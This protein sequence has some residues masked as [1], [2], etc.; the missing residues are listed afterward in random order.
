MTRPDLIATL[1]TLGW[2]V[3]GLARLL[4]RSEETVGSWGK[5][6]RAVPQDVAKWLDRRV[7]SLKADPPPTS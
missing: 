3:R 4:G 5:P 2:T 7:A 1:A 6:G